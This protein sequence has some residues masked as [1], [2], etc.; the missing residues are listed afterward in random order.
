MNVWGAKVRSPNVNRAVAAWLL[1]A[2][3]MGRAERRY[4]ESAV[5]PGQI[6]VD[7]GANQGIF[8]LLFS[9]LVGPGGRVFALEPE[10]AL[11]AALDGNCARNGATNVTRLRVAAGEKRSHGMLHCSRF[12]SGDNTMTSSRSGPSVPVEIVALDEVL[13][14]EE[15]SLIK[16]DV[17]GY[18]L[19]V[20]KGMEALLKRSPGV[21][22]LF[23]YWPA[24]LRRAGCAPE[25]LLEFFRQRGFSLFEIDGTELKKLSGPRA[26]QLAGG[27]DWAWNNLVAAQEPVGRNHV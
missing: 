5:S 27:S 9:R 2:G 11:F 3:V 1:N 19:S 23:E 15:V 7:V 26:A 22:V 12:N 16:V 13:P 20:V 18:E 25:E 14:V 24:G 21:K 6:V 17:Q 4:F 10:P 8:T